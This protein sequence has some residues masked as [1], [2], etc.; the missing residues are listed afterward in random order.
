MYSGEL[1]LK[2]ISQRAYFISLELQNSILFPFLHSG[3]RD[4]TVKNVV[5][6]FLLFD[7]NLLDD[8]RYDVEFGLLYGF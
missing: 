6:L 3:N 2:F 1:N 7:D 4:I 5:L 8:G